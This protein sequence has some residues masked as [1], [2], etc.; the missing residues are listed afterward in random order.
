MQK[1]TLK[2]LKDTEQYRHLEHDPTPENNATVNKVITRFKNDKL[3]SNNVSDGLK[4]ESPRRWFFYTQTKIHKV[5]NP[6]RPVISPLNFHT[7][8]VSEYVDFHL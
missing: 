8:K 3:I 6:G 7:S 2:N 1:T 5:G 4:V